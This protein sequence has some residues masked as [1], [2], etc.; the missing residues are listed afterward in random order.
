M[1][2]KFLVLFLLSALVS[3]SACLANTEVQS[4]EEQANTLLN[5]FDKNKDGKI[6][7]DET[8]ESFNEKGF[9]AAD[10]NKDEILTKDELVVYYTNLNGMKKGWW[11]KKIEFK[12]PMKKQS[13]K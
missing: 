5:N 7:K 2:S 6:T 8:P 12:N 1:K 4:P 11:N 9:I 13:K 10:K 3:T